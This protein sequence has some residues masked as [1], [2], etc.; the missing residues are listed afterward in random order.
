VVEAKGGDTDDLDT[1]IE[2]QERALAAMHRLGGEKLSSTGFSILDEVI[3]EI[4]E[5]IDRAL[6][7]FGAESLKPGFFGGIALAGLEATLVQL[8]GTEAGTQ[9]TLTLTQ[10][11]EGDT[12]IEQNQAMFDVAR[13]NLTLA[14]FIDRYGH[15]TVEEMELSRPRWREDPS[16]VQQV[17][18]AYLDESVTAPGELH[19][20]NA[21]RC[22][23]SEKELPETLRQWGGSSLLEGVLVDLKDAQA[24]LPYREAGKHYLMMGYE[25]IRL[26]ILELARRWDMGRDVF[27]LKWDELRTYEGTPDGLA[28]L[29]GA[30][31]T[32]WQSARRLDMAE[33]V[34]SE[35][36]DI[37][38]LPKEYDDAQELAG[39]PVASGVATGIARI[40]H[41]PT[42]TADLRTDYILVCH[43]TDPGW[44]AL[45]VHARAVIVE[46]GGI[47]SHG[48]IVARDFG[49]PAVVCPDATRR[50]PDKANIRVDG[51]R[52]TITLLDE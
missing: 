13:G 51:N 16:Y 14:E 48:A 7:D 29:I 24:L 6:T 40:V 11:L 33:V 27:F 45:F 52:G 47:L 46:Q 32:R 20:R 12:T 22:A 35:H 50:I 26:G 31:K 44:T 18:G 15:R 9:L 17:L 1:E 4:S 30:R 5:R 2:Q 28:G 42:Q 19:D 49:I 23:R 34:D 21:E 3:D 10:G 43:S 39:E 25:T 37:L 38:G 36:L 41:D 8:M